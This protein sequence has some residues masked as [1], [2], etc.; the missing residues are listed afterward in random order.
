[1]SSSRTTDRIRGLRCRS[2]ACPRN[3]SRRGRGGWSFRFGDHWVELGQLNDDAFERPPYDLL[4]DIEEYQNVQWLTRTRAPD[5]GRDLS[6]T[7]SSPST[8][9]PT[10]VA[11]TPR[12]P[13]P[14][15]SSPVWP[16]R[17]VLCPP[18]PGPTRHIHRWPW[19]HRDVRDGQ[20]PGPGHADTHRDRATAWLTRRPVRRL[21]RGGVALHRA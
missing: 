17:R 16:V 3:R 9:R 11:P 18:V 6:S 21:P 2:A 20:P 10:W 5:R 8:S 4:R 1:M 7:V 13:P 14:S 15:C 19:G 12:P